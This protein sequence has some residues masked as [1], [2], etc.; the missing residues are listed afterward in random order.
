MWQSVSDK[1]HWFPLISNF[2]HFRFCLICFQEAYNKFE[3]LFL[4]LQEL[5]KILLEEILHWQKQLMLD[6][7]ELKATVDLER[8]APWWVKSF[9][10]PIFGRKKK[11]LQ[12]CLYFD[13]LFR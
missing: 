11:R 6:Y 7:V 10:V 1:Q 2:L 9:K 12:C 4:D 13:N 8:F 3:A 5:L